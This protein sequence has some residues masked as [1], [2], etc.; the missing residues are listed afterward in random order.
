MT[1]LSAS[2]V[3]RALACPASLVLPRSEYHT[4]DAEDGI[5]RH[6]AMEAAARTEDGAGLPEV[7]RAL[8]QPGDRIAAE[9]SF[10]Y[11]VAT[12]TARELGH[13]HGRC[14]GELRPFE[15]PG[16][17]D[18]LI[19]GNGRAIVVDYK[20]FEPVAHAETNEQTATYALMVSR[21]YGFRCVTV[22]IVYLVGDRR[23]SMATLDALDLDAHAQRLKQLHLDAAKARENPEP[24]LF[25]G[26][27]CKYCKAFLACPRQRVVQD[28]VSQGLVAMRVEAAIPF[29]DDGE[30]ARAYELLGQVKLLA[31]R[32]TAALKARAQER[33][34]PLLSGKMYG[35]VTKNGNERLNADVVYEVVREK[36][37]QGIADAA[38]ERVATKKRLKD[39]LAFAGAK[40]AA[41]AER[42]VLEAVRERGGATRETKT[43]IEEYEPQLALEAG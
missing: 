20:G 16:T 3:P 1:L 8:F 30:A 38:V 36:H 40:P 31:Q 4:E 32:L 21:A 10:A 43:V 29:V 23:P 42:D 28:E 34:I 41:A 15:I 37:G 11:D 13:V 9:C 5:A 6:A 24:F 27:H 19:V 14:Y 26:S 18:L 25:V 7:V 17:A 2:E 22:A 39:A 35:P 12:D 33:P